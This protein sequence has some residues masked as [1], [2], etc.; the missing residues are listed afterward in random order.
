MTALSFNFP[1]WSRFGKSCL[2]LSNWAPSL[3]PAATLLTVS[4]L[5][6]RLDRGK[7]RHV[8]TMPGLTEKFAASLAIT[9]A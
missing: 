2:R 6:D 4:D 5:R 3:I 7:A 1:T 8:I 9:L